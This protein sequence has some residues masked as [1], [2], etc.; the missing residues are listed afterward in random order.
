M[1][2]YAPL[3][4]E[5]SEKG[6]VDVPISPP[7]VEV[8]EVQ[9]PQATC[10]YSRCCGCFSLATG[11]AILAYF[12]LFTGV[13]QLL[14]AT[15]LL[16]ARTHEHAIDNAMIRS[17][18]NVTATMMDQKVMKLNAGIDMA[19]EVSPMMLLAAFVAIMAG[20][21]GLKASKGDVQSARRY[22]VWKLATAVWVLLSS[23]FSGGF[24]QAVLSVYFAL[25]ARSLWIKLS[26]AEMTVL[27]TVAPAPASTPAAPTPS[28]P[29]RADTV[30]PIA[31]VGNPVN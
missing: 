26:F 12:D 8:V 22:Y 9:E 21:W 3:P 30:N 4:A 1:A 5:A 13:T 18:T 27:P 20:C 10:M 25:V 16:F 6:M 14:M 19:A 11:V 24:M 31:F 2:S 15:G 7:V 29:M 23:F 28:A 17:M